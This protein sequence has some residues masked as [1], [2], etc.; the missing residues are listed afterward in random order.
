MRLILAA[1]TAA[2]IA[3]AARADVEQVLTGHALPGY[4]AFAS[5]TAQ[6]SDAAAASCDAAALKPAFTAAWD[7][8]FG[9]AHLHLGPG[10]EAG[11]ALAI[12]FWPDP[13]GL[14]SKAQRALLL[15]D[16]ANL[17]PAAFADQSVAARG[18]PGLERL[19]YATDPPAA[20]PCP[21]IRATAQDLARLA[22]EIE[23]GWTGPQGFAETLRTAGQ[24]GNTRYLSEN[25]AKQALF[26]QFATGLEVVADQR[27]GRPLGTFDKP[28]PER[29]EAR[30]SGRGCRHVVLSLQALRAMATNLDPK[31]TK[32]LAGFDAVIALAE[33]LPADALTRTDDPQIWLKVQI[34]QERI[35]ALRDQGIAEIA[36][37]LGVGVG[38]N[39]QDGD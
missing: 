6:L 28:R 18:F 21:L 34:L 15:G 16:P 29:A 24:P 23:A 2:L 30:A 9:V 19:L 25:E 3:P 7:A 32:T 22:A 14:G 10:E 27:L 39:S 26:T 31:A 5:A 33:K 11:R 8:W 38:F 12:S 20:D 36:P 1:L 37:A 17:E 13:K 35:R 4:A